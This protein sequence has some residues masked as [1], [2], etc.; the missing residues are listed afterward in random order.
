MDLTGASVP[1]GR[2][3]FILQITHLDF[4][5]SDS[6]WA[7][8]LRTMKCQVSQV[9]LSKF[10]IPENILGVDLSVFTLGSRFTETKVV[11]EGSVAAPDILQVKLPVFEGD[12]GLVL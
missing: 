10:Y 1:S 3:T 4:C 11:D 8:N 9:L 12:R 5:P 7:P 2:Y 6:I